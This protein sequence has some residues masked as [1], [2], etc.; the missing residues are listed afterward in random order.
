MPQNG[1]VK[2]AKWDKTVINTWGHLNRDSVED[3]QEAERYFSYKV[4]GGTGHNMK[5]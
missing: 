2:G 5:W 1:V 4:L 3:H